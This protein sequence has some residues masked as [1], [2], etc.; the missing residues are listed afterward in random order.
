MQEATT[1]ATTATTTVDENL[2][3]FQWLRNK[4]T[5]KNKKI[6]D[7]GTFSFFW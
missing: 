6:T 3:R 5:E 7:D 1:T 4:L 2:G